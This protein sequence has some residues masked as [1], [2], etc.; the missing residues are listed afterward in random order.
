MTHSIWP[1]TLSRVRGTIDG[2]WIGNRNTER[3]KLVTT[4][5]YSAVAN[6]H[7]LQFTTAHTKSLSMLCFHRLSGN[8]FQRRRS[9][10]F[11]VPTLRSSLAVAYLRTVLGVAWLQYPNKGYSSRPY[12]SRTAVPNRCLKTPDSREYT[13]QITVSHT[14]FPVTV[15]T[16]LLGNIFQQSTFLCSRA[17]VLAGWRLSQN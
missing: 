15:F 7:T 17:H 13:L 12:C 5:N 11:R 6:S 8:G 10:S 4:S 1:I 2:V 9:L 14:L 3:L 16:A